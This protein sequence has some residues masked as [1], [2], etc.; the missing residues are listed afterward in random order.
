VNL[1][2]DKEEDA[3]VKAQEKGF[4]R[5]LIR[6]AMNNGELVEDAP[7]STSTMQWLQ[8]TGEMRAKMA[9]FYTLVEHNT[10]S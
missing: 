9:A 4:L 5:E 6:I 7:E 8:C 3:F 10:K 1:Y 2:L